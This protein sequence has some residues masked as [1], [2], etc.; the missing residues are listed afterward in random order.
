MKSMLPSSRHEVDG[1]RICR[2]SLACTPCS[3]V[4]RFQ[5]AEKERTEVVCS[6]EKRIQ[7]ER[8]SFQ[9]A[10]GRSLVKLLVSNPGSASASMGRMSPHEVAVAI[11]CSTHR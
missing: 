4:L 9:K 5:A 1:R 6:F 8:C 3:S 2:A 11:Y 7:R 10:I